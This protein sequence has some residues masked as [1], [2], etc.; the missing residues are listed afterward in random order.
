MTITV[1]FWA[2]LVAAIIEMAIGALWYSPVLFGKPWLRAMGKQPGD[3]MGGKAGVGY[4]ASLIAALVTAYILA[5]FVIYAGSYNG[6]YSAAGGALAGFWAWLGF[7]ITTAISSTIFESRPWSLYLMNVSYYLVS[8]VA[9]G[10]LL[11]VWH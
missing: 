11:A 10:A 3:P 5:H 4:V 1:N 8:F 9:M 7:V 6:V 2:V